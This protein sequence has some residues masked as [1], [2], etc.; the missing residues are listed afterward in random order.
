MIK[1]IGDV[2]TVYIVGFLAV[3]SCIVLVLI[4]RLLLEGFARLLDWLL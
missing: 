4:V 3:G 1:L 2:V